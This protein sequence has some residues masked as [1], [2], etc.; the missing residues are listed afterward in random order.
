MIAVTMVFFEM[1]ITAESDT[2]REVLKDMHSTATSGAN[3]YRVLFTRWFA[4]RE[5]AMTERIFTAESL[6]F[7]CRV[8]SISPDR[9]ITRRTR[10]FFK[11]N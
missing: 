10:N 9:T 3:N 2:I 8:L 4:G 11:M 1:I 6:Q 5:L 7:T